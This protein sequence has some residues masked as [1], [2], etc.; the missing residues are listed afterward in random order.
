MWWKFNTIQWKKIVAIQIATETREKRDNWLD[1]KY[2]GIMH[3]K[4]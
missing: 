3:K 1:G 4:I 2:E